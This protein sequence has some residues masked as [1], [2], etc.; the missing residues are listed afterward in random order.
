M[1][2]PTSTGKK[3]EYRTHFLHHEYV[4]HILICPCPPAKPLGAI[5][6]IRHVHPTKAPCLTSWCLG[7]VGFLRSIEQRLRLIGY[8]LRAK[9]G[10][11]G[12]LIPW[13][14]CVGWAKFVRLSQSKKIKNTTINRRVPGWL[15]KR[16]CS[17]KAAM[18]L[19]QK[20]WGI[21]YAWWGGGED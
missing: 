12:D 20:F 10:R 13:P 9:F 17:G 14:N 2:V 19:R 21:F 8:I 5:K 6:Q 15:T 4:D 1:N 3:V 7:V 11:R 16:S 18:L